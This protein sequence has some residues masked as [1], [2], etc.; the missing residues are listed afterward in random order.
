MNP[1]DPIILTAYLI[2]LAYFIYK[3]IDSFN[4]EYTARVDEEPLKQHLSDNNL[5][6]VIGISFGFAKRYEFNKLD[7]LPISISNKSNNY[8][9]YV[10]WDYS[11]F[12]DFEKRARR[13]TRLAPGTTLDLSQTQVFSAVAPNTTLKETITAEDLLQRKGE[14]KDDK[15]DTASPL[16]LEVE[17]TKPLVDLTKPPDSIKKQFQKFKKRK[18]DLDFSLELVFRVVGPD[19]ALSGDRIRIPCKFILKK[20][21]WTAGLPWNPK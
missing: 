7:R 12:T 1:V 16:N 11:T 8:S 4:D 5:Q 13:V 17:I 19:R 20:L 3:I 15:L 18:A 14:R 21:P 6:D 9:I 2:C 10:D